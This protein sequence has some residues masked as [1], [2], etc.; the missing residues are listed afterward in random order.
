MN[1]LALS[2]SPL[3]SARVDGMRRAEERANR[4]I[5]EWSDLAMVFLTNY[6]RTNE[7]V[8]AE[9][10]TRAADK[11]GMIAPPDSRAWGTIYTQAIREKIIAKTTETRR[12][13]NG[14]LAMVYRS[15]VYR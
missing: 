7:F 15:L 11:W 12:R 9:D 14:S 13:A 2:F 4:E 1:Q 10:V 5:A 8:F 3:P 6:A